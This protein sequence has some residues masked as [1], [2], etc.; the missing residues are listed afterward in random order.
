MI[1]CR[2]CGTNAEIVNTK[3]CDH[4]PRGIDLVQKID[5]SKLKVRLSNGAQHSQPIV[6]D[7]TK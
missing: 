6:K 3:C 2:T 4:K 5:T 1:K 7:E